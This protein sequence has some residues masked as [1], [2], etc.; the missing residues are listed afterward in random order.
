VASRL[1]SKFQSPEILSIFSPPP[2]TFVLA[3]LTRRLSPHFISKANV[4][5]YLKEK[6]QGTNM[7][8]TILRPV[9]FMDNF[10]PGWIGKIFPTAWSVALAP[11]TKLQLIATSVRIN[12]LVILRTPFLKQVLTYR[13]ALTSQPKMENFD[14][15]SPKTFQNQKLTSRSQTG[16]W[17]VRSTGALKAKRIQWS[18]N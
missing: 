1:E 14:S 7:S 3:I 18:C 9:A 13:R 4:E 8:W 15:I 5:K 17:M 10:T 12:S 16:H 11:T 6:S 2:L